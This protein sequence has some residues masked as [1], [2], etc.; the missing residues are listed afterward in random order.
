MSGP[1]RVL[2]L[3][4]TV[5]ILGNFATPVALSFAVL[6]L[7]PGP[8]AASRLALV[9]VAAAVPQLLFLAVGGA[10]AIV[11]TG[12]CLPLAARPARAWPRQRRRSSC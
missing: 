10:A 8:E 2:V 3:A 11:A 6:A 1:Q 5:S 9:L 7:A 4:R 12:G